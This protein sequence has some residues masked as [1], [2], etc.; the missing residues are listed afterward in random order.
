MMDPDEWW[1][2]AARD[3]GWWLVWFDHYRIFLNHHAD[4]AQSTG[5][6]YLIIGGD[7]VTP[8]LPSGQL[9][10]GNASGVPADSDSRWRNILS[11]LR[12]HYS[13]QILWALPLDQVNTPPQFIDSVDGIYL[14]WQAPL[15]SEPGAPVSDLE[16]EAGR[17]LDS[18]VQ[19][20]QT[21]FNKPI[22]IGI[23]YPSATG[24][25]TACISTITGTCLP[26]DQANTMNPE[27]FTLS[28]NLQEQVEAYSGLLNAIQ[29]R[30]WIN[31]VIAR[32]Y[33]PPVSLIDPGNSGH[34]KPLS[35]LLS[36]WF[37]QTP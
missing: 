17:I 33:Y 1:A 24:S 15:A 37:N 22:Y 10:D 11:E 36:L 28:L 27:I 5:S 19:P 35:D 21:R 3:F 13:G 32:G 16:I 25:T 6:Q 7:G 30:A 9:A 20:V 26:P 12:T 4:L 34:G 18:L 2:G 8:A 23:N 14:L 31:G 29:K